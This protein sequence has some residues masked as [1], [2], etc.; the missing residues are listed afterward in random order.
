MVVAPS[1]AFVLA[2]AGLLRISEVV[3]LRVGDVVFPEDPRFWGVDFVVLALAHTKT[4]DDLSAEIRDAWVW[5]LLRL[6][7]SVRAPAGQAARL[8][9][10]AV[11]LRAARWS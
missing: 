2:F 1:F 11:D 10:S 6:W 9:P 5:P 3:G 7:H 8:F 4:G